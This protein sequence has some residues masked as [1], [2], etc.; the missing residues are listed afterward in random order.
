MS[1]KINVQGYLDTISM[2]WGQLFYKMIW[3]NLAYQGKRILDFGSGP[4]LTAD[5]L[6]ENNTVTA[7]EPNEEMITYRFHANAYEQLCGSIEELQ[8]FPADT[9]D[10]IVCH[11]VLEYVDNREEIFAAF[12]RVLKP[13]GSISLVKHNKWGKV[14]Q[15]AVFE[16]K[17]DEALSLLHNENVASVNFGTINEYD[18]EEL[19]NYIEGKFTVAATYGVRIFYALQRNE[20]KMEADWLEKMYELECEVE[21]IPTFR[22]IAFFHHIILKK[23]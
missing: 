23:I 15:K 16:Y 13:G 3:H 2:P 10:V 19:H 4:G 6:A 14:M 17:I 7:V 22:D 8:R 18:D 9:F 1:G 5:F 20:L 11:N 12:H 21:E